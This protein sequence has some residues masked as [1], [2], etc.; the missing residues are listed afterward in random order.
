[1]YP[2]PL[3]PTTIWHVSLGDELGMDKDSP[4]DRSLDLHNPIKNVAP[5]KDSS[6]ITLKP[7]TPK[8]IS[9]TSQKKVSPRVSRIDFDDL[10]GPANW[11]KYFENVSSKDNDF[12]LFSYLTK[13]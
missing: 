3:V 4:T 12:D 5:G 6:I 9:S 1:M 13:K 8:N 10:Y 2:A 11:T 7:Y